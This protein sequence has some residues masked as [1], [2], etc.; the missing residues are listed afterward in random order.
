MQS[1]SAPR[2]RSRLFPSSLRT[3]RRIIAASAL[4]ALGT[5]FYLA[6]RVARD[7]A[8]ACSAQCPLNQLQLA[9]HNYH[10]MYRCF[11]PAYL[12]DATGTPIHS[13]RVLILPFIEEKSLYDA[14]RF[15]EPWNGPNNLKLADRMPQIFHIPSEPAS[16]AL[17]NI[18]AIVGPGTAFPG[19]KCTRMEEYA[20]GLDNTILL[21]ETAASRILWLEPN[22]LH[23]EG[24]SFTVSSHEKPSISCSRRGGPYVVFADSIHAYELNTS[25]HSEALRALTT[26]AGGEKMYLA[27]YADTGLTSPVGGPATDDNIRQLNL[28][29]LYALWLSRSDVTDDALGPLATA[30][31]LYRLNLRSTR[32]TDEG[33]KKLQQ[34]LPGC[35]ITR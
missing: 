31:C 32:T 21:V 5:W 34:A 30:P 2:H 17:T 26:I 24:M 22:D 23:V 13:W 1:G 33:V 4:L 16:T 10:E 18:V 7:G 29:G 28:D 8:L 19:S 9:L 3:P 20:D 12:A 6:V 15:D 27:E 14:Y 25:L 11:P 35:Q